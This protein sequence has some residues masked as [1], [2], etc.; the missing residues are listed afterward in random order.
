MTTF[1]DFLVWYTN[2]DV[3]PLVTAVTRL[4]Q[5]YFDR[6]IDLVKIAMSVP[7][8]AK[9]ML[10]DTA[11]REGAEFMLLDGKNKDLYHNI[12]SNIVGGPSIIYH[13]KVPKSL[14]GRLQCI[15]FVVYRTNMPV[16]VMVRRRVE[17]GFKP[18]VRDKNVSVDEL[19]D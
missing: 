1:R 15:V 17:E 16:G 4:Q 8:I 14:R 13:R 10:F 19:F 6:N 2:L 5:F 18:V 12:K 11:T 9:K 7:G 3:G